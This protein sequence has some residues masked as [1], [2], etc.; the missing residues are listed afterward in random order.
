MSEKEK[1]DPAKRPDPRRCPERCCFNWVEQGD[2]FAPG[3]F[4]DLKSAL[5]NVRRAEVGHCGL[6]GFASCCRLPES[7]GDVDLYEPC[8]PELERA[9][10]PWF[11]FVSRPSVLTAEARERYEREAPAYWAK[12]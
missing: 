8:E 9:G 11:F 2:S 12:K 7:P 1:I 10:L 4:P 6:V 3:F 5:S